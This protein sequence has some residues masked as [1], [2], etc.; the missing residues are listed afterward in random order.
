MES[1]QADVVIVGA[2]GAGLRAA[3][4]IA[5][6]D[7]G[8][9]VALVSKVYPMRS[10]TCAA[11]GGAAGVKGADD[12]LD[13]HFNDTVSGGDWLCDQEV[14][15]YFVRQAPQELIRLEHWGCPWSREDDG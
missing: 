1:I 10:H 7:P 15:E 6:A 2:G 4:A 3:I 8:L 9:E 14:V 12:S 11:E 13:N 5:E